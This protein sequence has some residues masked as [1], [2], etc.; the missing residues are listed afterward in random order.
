MDGGGVEGTVLDREPITGPVGVTLV[1]GGGGGA[2]VVGFEA[3][4][5]SGWLGGG[6]TG[7][8]EVEERAGEEGCESLMA[9]PL[10]RSPGEVASCAIGAPLGRSVSPVLALVETAALFARCPGG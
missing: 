7:A 2:E 5:G 1:C 6:A 9:P 3:V 4:V 10:G 8:F